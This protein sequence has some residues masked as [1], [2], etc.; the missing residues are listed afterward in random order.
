MW[1]CYNQKTKQINLKGT[2]NVEIVNRLVDM[3]IVGW[4]RILII[5]IRQNERENH[6]KTTLMEFIQIKAKNRSENLKYVLII[7]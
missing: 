4:T 6:T 2:N 7:I 3:G 1:H 5:K